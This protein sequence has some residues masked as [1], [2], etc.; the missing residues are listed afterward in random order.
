MAVALD[1]VDLTP[2]IGTEIKTD[3]ARLE[4]IEKLV[5]A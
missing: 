2:R 4:A 1:T 5:G 3:A